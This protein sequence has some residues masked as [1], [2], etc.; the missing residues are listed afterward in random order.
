METT[1]SLRPTWPRW[2]VAC[3]VIA[4]ALV[5][6]GDQYPLSPFPMYS[7]V[8]PS[9]DILYVTDQNDKPLA[10]SSLFDVGSAQ[11]KKRFEKELYAIS[12]TRDYENA[13]PKDVNKAAENFLTKLWAGRNNSQVKKTD[14]LGLKQLKA[15]IITV[16][17]DE[18]SKFDRHE[19]PLGQIDIPATSTPSSD[20]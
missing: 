5:G 4:F 12:K 16:S 11:G 17:L 7:N 8:E 20:K 18:Q 10:I 13:K 6:I 3:I 2:L 15:R 1:T 9:V 19:H 14:A